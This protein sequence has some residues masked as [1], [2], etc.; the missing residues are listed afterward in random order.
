MS[1]EQPGDRK[2]DG[3]FAPGNSSAFQPGNRYAEAHWW[4]PGFCPNPEGRPTSFREEYCALVVEMG[5]R[6]KT[7]AQMAAAIGVDK[8]TLTNWRKD[9]PGTFG[10]AMLLAETCAQAWWEDLGQDGVTTKEFNGAVYS[11]S[12]ACRFRDD[13]TEKS[14]HEVTGA[15][16]AP[17]FTGI[18]VNFVKPEG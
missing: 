5:L 6:G 12:M 18:T 15:D 8:Q 1:D 10:T 14:A 11:R 9:F 3:R 2:P 13:W 16:G 4:K 7:K 17:L